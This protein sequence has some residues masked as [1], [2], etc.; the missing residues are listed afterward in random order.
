MEKI[1]VIDDDVQLSKLIE[2]FL[3]TFNYEVKI[4]HEPEIALKFLEKNYFKL[5]YKVNYKY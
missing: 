3:G 5:R 2:E 4:M 1:L